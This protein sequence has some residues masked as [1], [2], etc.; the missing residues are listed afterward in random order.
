M[1]RSVVV[2]ARE[3]TAA[4]AAAPTAIAPTRAVRRE[5]SIVIRV[6]FLSEQA[7]KICLV[8][9][10][11]MVVEIVA[12]HCQHIKGMQRVEIGGAIDARTMASLR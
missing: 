4:T 2:A 5:L 3:G 1:I 8:H 12:V 7:V 9:R 11:R 10:K 6:S